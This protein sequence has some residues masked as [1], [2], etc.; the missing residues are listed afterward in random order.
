MAQVSQALNR[1]PGLVTFAAILMFLLG[2]FQI[3]WAFVEFANA[4]WIA[5]NVYGSFGGYLWLWGILDII[6]ALVLFYA[7]FDVLAGGTFGQVFGLVAAGFSAIRWFFYIPAAP[8]VAIVI[9]AMDVLV[10]YGLLAH[11]EYFQET[12]GM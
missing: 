6:F 7:G 2:G 4:T 9:I 3:T 10:L 5:A 11:A 1:R 8:W 12:P